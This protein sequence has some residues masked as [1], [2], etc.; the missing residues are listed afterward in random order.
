MPHCDLVLKLKPHAEG[1]ILVLL[2][3]WWRQGTLPSVMGAGGLS[4]LES[5][6]LWEF[7][8][9]LCCCSDLICISK[10]CSKVFLSAVMAECESG[11]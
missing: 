10:G 5:H 6:Q 4:S 2:R 11:N 3:F 8:V 7:L 9:L 1:L